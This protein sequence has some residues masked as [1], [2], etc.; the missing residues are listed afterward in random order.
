LG[1]QYYPKD[2]IET[3][4]GLVFAVVEQGLEQGKVLCFLRYIKEEASWIKVNTQEAN[5]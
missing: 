5:S 4:Q 3:K 1:A 2:F